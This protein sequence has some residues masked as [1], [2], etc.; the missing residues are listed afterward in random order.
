MVAVFGMAFLGRL[1]ARRLLA[2]SGHGG[3]GW[4]VVGHG[5]RD[6]REQQAHFRS[7]L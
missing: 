5:G 3:G 7:V 4:Q 1:T 2:P 6:G